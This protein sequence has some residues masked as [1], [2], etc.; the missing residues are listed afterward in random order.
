MR[1][2]LSVADVSSAEFEA[3][4]SRAGSIKKSIKQRTP[5]SSLR[6]KIAGILF[7]KP[8]TRTRTSFEAA[9]IRLGGNA[10]YLSAN[11]L[12][13]SRGEPIKD[14]ARILGG[15]LDAIVARVYSHDTVLQFSEFSGVPVINA[16]SDLEHPTQIVSDYLTISEVK[17]KLRGLKLAYIGDGDNVCNSLLLGA[18][19]VGM[20]MSVACPQGYEPPDAFLQ[21]ARALAGPTGSG[22]DVVRDPKEAV[23]GADVLYTDVWVSMG[24]EQE[25]DRRMRDF[26]GYQINSELLGAAKTDAVVMHCLPAHR[27]LEITDDV[28]EGERSIVW[29]QGE[30]KLYGAAAVLDWLLGG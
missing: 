9:A 17:G 30:N 19:L 12:Q 2:F 13:L 4:L 20:D 5:L 26:Q 11:E 7:E 3:L 25:K 15:Y 28:I 6:G 23:K 16:L 24:E 29:R 21:K 27:G 10:I 14:T 8:S 22:I 1:S 18:A